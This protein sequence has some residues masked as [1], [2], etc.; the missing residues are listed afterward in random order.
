MTAEERNLRPNEQTLDSWKAIAAYLKRDVRTVRRWEKSEGLPVRRHL[1]QAQSTVYAYRSEI[2]AWATTRQPRRQE[3]PAWRRRVPALSFAAVLML[4]LLL[5]ADAPFSATAAAAQQESG[6]SKSERAVWT[7]DNVPLMG[8][9]SP[10]GRFIA[11]RNG[12]TGGLMIH[13][14]AAN[15]NRTLTPEPSSYYA[16]WTRHAVF[17][18][19]NKQVVYEWWDESRDWRLAL[20]IATIPSTGFVQPREFFL[21]GDDIAGLLGFDWSPDGK[22]VAAALR[23]KDRTG[24]IVLIAVAD[25]SLRVLKSTDWNLPGRI[26]FSPDGRYIAYHLP[27][28]DGSGHLDVF[29]LPIDGS[30]EIPAVVHSANDRVMGWSPDGSRLLFLS[31][32]TGAVSLWALPFGDGNVQGPPELVKSGVGENSGGVWAN[33]L[34]VTASGALYLHKRI[35]SRDVAI[36]PIDLAAGKL[37]GPPKS[38]AQGFVLDSRNLSWSPDGKYLAYAGQDGAV[39][40]IRSVATGQVRRLPTVGYVQFLNWSPDGRSLLARGEDLKGRPGLFRIDVQSGESTPVA[41]TEHRNGPTFAKWSPDGKKVYFSRAAYDQDGGPFIEK[42]LTTGVERQVSRELAGPVSLN[43]KY[44]AV[45][46]PDS[47]LVVPVDGGQPHELVRLKEPEKFVTRHDNL[48]SRRE[49]WT[50]DS[51]AVLVVKDTGS[52]RELW[53][54][55]IAD[56]QPRKI[57]I[58]PDIWMNG[59]LAPGSDGFSLSP[60]G[61]SIAFQMGKQSDEV[62]ALENFLPGLSAAK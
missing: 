45:A 32:R 61:R 9:V 46:H 55:P 60:D 16:Q 36:A 4:S 54:F 29:V 11:T 34:G 26:F 47:L 35:D 44:F 6:Q 41:F 1:H 3:I 10:D 40:A 51:S 39:I 43:G 23:H 13:D 52:R 25:G 7:G 59:S 19:D 18:Q 62:W 50:P 48:G 22:W 31:D 33:T 2:D 28:S 56:G 5:V 12:D 17:S 30:R 38:F 21:S 53:L 8:R 14:I 15:T 42:D 57:D 24:Q 49:V 37:L 20:R 58:D 27:S